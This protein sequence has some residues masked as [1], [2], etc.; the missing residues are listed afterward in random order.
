M[1]R[2]GRIHLEIEGGGLRHLLFIGGELGEAV[3][4]GRGQEKCQDASPLL[5]SK[6][7]TFDAVGDS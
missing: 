2:V 4:E 1:A 5:S 3:G 6:S 7:E